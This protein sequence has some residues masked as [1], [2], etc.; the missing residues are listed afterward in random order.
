MTGD[1]R[2][3]TTEDSKVPGHRPHSH[4][5][6]TGCQDHTPADRRQGHSLGG[7]Y[8]VVV[9]RIAHD[10]SDGDRVDDGEDDDN[11]EYDCEVV[12]RP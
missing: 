4:F 5:V 9:L 12:V 7:A 2:D 3:K 11:D 6:R 1:R 8:Q 10:Y